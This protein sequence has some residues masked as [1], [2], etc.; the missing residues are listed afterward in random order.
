MAQAVSVEQFDLTGY[1]AGTPIALTTSSVFNLYRLYTDIT[2]SAAMTVAAATVPTGV[3]V[4]EIVL[5]A[6]ITFGGGGSLTVFGQSVAES[7]CQAGTRFVVTYNGTSYSVNC[8]PSFLQSGF[9]QGADIASGTIALDRL[10]NLTAGNIIVGNA[11]NVPTSVTPSGDFTMSNAGVSTIAND[12]ITTVKIID[13]AVT[14]PKIIDEAVTLAKLSSAVQSQLNTMAAQSMATA[15]APVANADVLTLN[16][17]PIS[18]VAA[19]GAGLALQAVD[20]VAWVNYVATPY[21]TNTTLE[22]ITDTATTAQLRAT[23]LLA[24]TNSNPRSLGRVAPPTGASDTQLIA[25]KALTLFVPTGNPTG[26]GGTLQYIVFY[27]TLTIA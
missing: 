5:D 10:V 16:G 17:T 20:G 27:R 9:I 12:A 11:S 26:A 8:Q 14:T 24:A 18:I 13:D 15:S 23:S 7:Y 21:A 2:A 19:P 3:V 25:N 4:F 1:A 6:T 22:V